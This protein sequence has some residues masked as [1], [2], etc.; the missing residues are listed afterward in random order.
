[1]WVFFFWGGWG[2]FVSIMASW[3]WFQRCS[4][5]IRGCSYCGFLHW[6]VS[7]FVTLSHAFYNPFSDFEQMP[8]K[9][10]T[11][12]LEN[13]VD[14]HFQVPHR[15]YKFRTQKLGF[16]DFHFLIIVVM[17]KFPFCLLISNGFSFES[18]CRED[19]I[20]Y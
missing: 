19:K 18:S 14:S 5:I 4:L 15:D 10:L 1:M 20:F 9:V 2:D 6:F 12:E 8:T 17:C 3:P 16:H 13:H 7:I 11:W